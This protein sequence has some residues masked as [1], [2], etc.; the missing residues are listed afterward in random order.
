MFVNRQQ[1]LVIALQ[2]CHLHIRHLLDREMIQYINLDFHT[3]VLPP[4]SLTNGKQHVYCVSVLC[5]TKQ[6]VNIITHH[7]L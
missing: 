1:Y 6:K 7:S 2:H 4:G 3:F 5:Y